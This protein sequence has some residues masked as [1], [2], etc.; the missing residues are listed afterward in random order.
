MKTFVMPGGEL[1][2]FEMRCCFKKTAT[3][4]MARRLSNFIAAAW[5][6]FFA[7][8]YIKLSLFLDSTS[9]LPSGSLLTKPAL[10]TVFRDS[11][12]NAKHAKRYHRREVA[13]CLF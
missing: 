11:Y 4:A 5:F 9:V 1:V 10:F 6:V 12:R 8:K 3:S 7:S 13:P 2:I